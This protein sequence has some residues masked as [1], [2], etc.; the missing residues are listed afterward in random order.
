[1]RFKNN[2]S[3]YKYSGVIFFHSDKKIWVPMQKAKYVGYFLSFPFSKYALVYFLILCL[4]FLI[5]CD[6]PRAASDEIKIVEAVVGGKRL[7]VPDVYLKFG[8]TSL[9]AKTGFIQAYYPGSAPVPGDPQELW[10]QGEWQEK[11]IR[12][13]FTHYPKSNPIG[14]VETAIEHHKTNKT[15]GREFGGLLHVT[16]EEEEND[17]KN[18]IW[19][20]DRKTGSFISCSEEQYEGGNPQCSH[21]FYMDRI[22]FKISYSKKLLPEWKTIKQNAF[23]LYESFQ[24][25]E[26]ALAYVHQISS[27]P[28]SKGE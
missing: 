5:G 23:D 10:E 27:L 22:S 19:I 12:I 6:Q 21:R 7:Y 2:C 14:S 18:D 4:A 25:P 9:G 20:E 13:R 1:M 26:S 28:N 11:N 15:L 8:H 17:W 3:P 16:Q 24:N